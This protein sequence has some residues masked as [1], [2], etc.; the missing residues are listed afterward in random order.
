MDWVLAA[1]MQGKPA[2]AY[3]PYHADNSSGRQ[4]IDT[5]EAAYYCTG[6]RPEVAWLAQTVVALLQVVGF[7]QLTNRFFRRFY[8]ANVVT[9]L[10]DRR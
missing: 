6:T 3:R 8:H 1:V 5:I 10:H 4:R 7:K 9:E 2:L